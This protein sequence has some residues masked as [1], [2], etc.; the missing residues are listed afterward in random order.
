MPGSRSVET[1]AG[2]RGRVREAGIW[3]GKKKAGDEESEP[4]SIILNISFRR[5]SASQTPAVFRWLSLALARPLFVLSPRT[6]SLAQATL[7]RLI[8]RT[9]NSKYT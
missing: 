5:L 3:E 4:V 8:V 9:E 6:E 1:K 2:E 7:K